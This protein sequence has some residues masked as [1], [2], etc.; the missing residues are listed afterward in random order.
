M[1]DLSL[2]PVGVALALERRAA[3]LAA[4][5]ARMK[6]GQDPKA[7]IDQ[8][9][10]ARR[11]FFGDKRDLMVQMQRWSGD[12]LERLVPRLADL[13]RTLLTNSQAAELLLSQALAQ[14]ARVAAA[15]R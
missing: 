13:H 1:R 8:E 3:Q 15:R 12:K 5:T 11:V 14:I 2:N 6:P 7:L 10:T 9:A 4:L